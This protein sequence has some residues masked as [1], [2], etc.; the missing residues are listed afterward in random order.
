MMHWD[1]I[2]AACSMF[3]IL[4]TIIGVAYTSGR[5]TEKLRES[6]EKIE[7][8]SIALKEHAGRLDEHALSIDRLQQWREGFNAAANVSGGKV[9]H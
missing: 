3:G 7:E 8:H 6:R 5:M 9:V 4:A 1:A 2:A